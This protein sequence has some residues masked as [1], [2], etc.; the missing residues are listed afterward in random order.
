MFGIH[1]RA[2]EI[3]KQELEAAGIGCVL[4]NGTIRDPKVKQK[5]VDDFQSESWCRVFLGN[6]VSAGTGL[7]LTAA[8]QLDLLEASWVPA[9]NEQA[10]KR[11]H[12]ISQ[13][14]NAFVRF[15][16]LANS[17]DVDVMESL[18]EKAKS[19]AKVNGHESD[20]STFL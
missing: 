1:V 13:T 4:V 18:A 6:M 8:N 3:V 12:R 10:M 11:I 5:A 7:T 14:R 17:V 16:S 19:I 15:I 2:L 20:L 9:E